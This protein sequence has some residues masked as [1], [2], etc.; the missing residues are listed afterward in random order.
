MHC[1]RRCAPLPSASHTTSFD[2]SQQQGERPLSDQA[3][4]RITDQAVDSSGH[5]RPEALVFRMAM[6]THRSP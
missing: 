5:S 2:E 3:S 6:D 4:D 1:T